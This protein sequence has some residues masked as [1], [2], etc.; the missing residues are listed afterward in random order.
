LNS[1]GPA[2]GA[3]PPRRAARTPAGFLAAAE[4]VDRI[5]L[6]RFAGERDFGLERARTWRFVAYA[7]CEADPEGCLAAATQVDRVA[8]PRFAGERDFELE[9]A[10]AWRFVA[11][12]RHA[13]P[14][15]CLAAAMKRHHAIP[16]QLGAI[17][18]P[19]L[20]PRARHGVDP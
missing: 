2:R 6:P 12:A 9:R 20:E 5:A 8:L 1:N 3:L 17:D 16:R 19:F 4:Q 7:Q 15:G 10:Q 18:N 13:D 14:M 11:C